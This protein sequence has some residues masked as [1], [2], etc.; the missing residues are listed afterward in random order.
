MSVTERIEL[1]ECN[2]NMDSDHRGY[3]IDSNLEICFEEE[4]NNEQELE[5]RLLNLNKSTHREDFVET[6]VF[7]Y[8]K[9][10]LCISL[11]KF[12]IF[13]VDKCRWHYHKYT[14]SQTCDFSNAIPIDYELVHIE[15]C[16]DRSKIDQIYQDVT[17]VLQKSKKKIRRREKR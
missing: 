17:F 13:N 1:M 8:Y 15:R 7:F 10:Y 11:H 3:L 12:L 5:Q 4:F 6:C 2:K 14:L 9:K 16:K